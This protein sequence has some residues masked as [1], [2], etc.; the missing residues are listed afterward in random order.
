MNASK[1]AVSAKKRDAAKAEPPPLTL[2]DEVRISGGIQ[3]CEAI[4]VALNNLEAALVSLDAL[5]FLVSAK[6]SYG[7]ILSV[8]V[9]RKD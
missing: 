5:G 9:N 6:I 4:R 1:D 2:A 8:G 3:Y 7:R